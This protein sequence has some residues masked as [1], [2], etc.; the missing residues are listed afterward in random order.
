MSHKF[1]S[2]Y[3]VIL[4][5]VSTSPLSVRWRTQPKLPLLCCP[6]CFHFLTQTFSCYC[7]SSCSTTL[8]LFLPKFPQGSNHV[9]PLVFPWSEN[10]TS[11]L[12][13]YCRSRKSRPLH[14]V[15]YLLFP[16]INLNAVWGNTV[17]WSAALAQTYVMVSSSW[18][19]VMSYWGHL[20]LGSNLN[21]L[22]AFYPQSFVIYQLFSGRS[23]GFPYLDKY[24]YIGKVCSCVF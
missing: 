10:A 12:N 22:T 11:E 1:P 19:S 20:L 7:Q 5:N 4:S 16:K 8:L 13:V 24:E 3:F 23:I 14:V 18:H 6:F 15:M 17:I 9:L 2:M 21:C